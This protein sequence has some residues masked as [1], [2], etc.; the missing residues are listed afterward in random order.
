MN[1]SEQLEQFSEY[2]R[3]MS[4]HSGNA[5]TFELY[6]A[7]Y[8]AVHELRQSEESNVIKEYLELFRK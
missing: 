1:F 2:K 3:R 6:L 8:E 7:A 5:D 4:I